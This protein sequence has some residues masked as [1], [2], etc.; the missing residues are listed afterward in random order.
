HRPTL[1]P[2]TTLFRSLESL[3]YGDR[4]R[5]LADILDKYKEC[6][7]PDAHRLVRRIMARKKRPEVYEI[8]TLIGLLTSIRAQEWY[9]ERS[10]SRSEEHTSE[11]QSREN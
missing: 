9:F 7:G 10:R 8:G 6:I 2:Y 1:F 4:W 5:R 11:L 3:F